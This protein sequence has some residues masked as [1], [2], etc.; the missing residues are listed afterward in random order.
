MGRDGTDGDVGRVTY[1][2]TL[3]LRDA[4]VEALSVRKGEVLTEEVIRE[5]ANNLTDSLRGSFT[6]ARIHDT[7]VGYA[8]N[9]ETMEEHARRVIR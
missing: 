4:I 5:R 6:F 9:G 3:E 8:L 2:L 7:P 1:A